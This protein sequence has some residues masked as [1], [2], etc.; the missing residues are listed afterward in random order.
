MA[1][2][3]GRLAAMGDRCTICSKVG[4]AKAK[5]NLEI[6]QLPSSCAVHCFIIKNNNNIISNVINF[7]SVFYNLFTI[8]NITHNNVPSRILNHYYHE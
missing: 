3:A 1:L 5:R 2:H 8:Y 6:K 7:P 4:I